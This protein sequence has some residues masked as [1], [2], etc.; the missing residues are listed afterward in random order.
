MMVNSPVFQRSLTE[1]QLW[2]LIP[3]LAIRMMEIGC[4]LLGHASVMVRG[5]ACLRSSDLLS[6]ARFPR[7]NSLC[8][9]LCTQFSAVQMPLALLAVA[10][11]TKLDS[12][13]AHALPPSDH[14]AAAAPSMRPFCAAPIVLAAFLMLIE[15]GQQSP[16]EQLNAACTHSISQ[17]FSWEVAICCAGHRLHADPVHHPGLL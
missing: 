14:K 1:T 12:C 8:L 2:P 6:P 9:L 11:Y 15:V 16:S 10:V 3:M 17:P 5:A 13:S 7:E 4:F